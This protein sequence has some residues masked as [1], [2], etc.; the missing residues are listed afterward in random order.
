MGYPLTTRWDLLK[1]WFSADLRGRELAESS[2]YRT[3]SPYCVRC[4][5]IWV[6]VPRSNPSGE[7]LG[8]ISTVTVAIPRTRQILA[9]QEVHVPTTLSRQT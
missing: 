7:R 6:F 3:G 2:P 8:G 5:S 9:E 1:L 4:T